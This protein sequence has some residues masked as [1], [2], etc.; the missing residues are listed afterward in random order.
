MRRSCGARRRI[1]FELGLM[2]LLAGTL[3]AVLLWRG[4]G[5]ADAVPGAA[6]FEWRPGQYVQVL[7]GQGSSNDIDAG[8][9]NDPGTKNAADLAVWAQMAWENQWGYVWGTFG[10]VLD[11]SLLRYKIEQFGSAVSDYEPFIRERWLGRR[12]ADCAGLIKSYGWF[13]AA[14]GTIDYGSGGMPDVGTDGMYDAAIVKG[15]IDTL[16]ETPGL[17]LY[18]P[19]HVGVYMGDGWAVEAIGT[20]G[21]VVRTRVA[22]RP[23]TDWL[24]CP[25]IQY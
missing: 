21:G 13:D 1:K 10:T 7:Y 9:L 11:E 22:D 3:A 25:Y 12:T 5:G 16:P 18:A 6:L 15:P 19:G 17:V 24:E 20:E 14:A 8:R 4:R 2:L 23:W